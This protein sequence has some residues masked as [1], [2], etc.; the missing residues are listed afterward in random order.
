VPTPPPIVVVPA[1]GTVPVGQTQALQVS[2]VAGT[3]ALTVA[4]PSIVDASVDQ[5]SRIV[6]LTG[7]QPGSTTLTVTDS[8]GLTRVVPIR[9]AYS[10]GTVAPT[11]SIRITGDPASIAFVKARAVA[12]ARSLAQA[13]TGAQIVVSNNDAV[14]DQ[15][16]GQDD[17]ADVDVPILIQGES[18]FSVNAT[19]R[20]H[21][22]NVAA[23][24]IAPDA[25]MVSDFP[26]TLTEDGVL[27]TADLNRNVPSRFLY[28]HANP[29]GQPDRRIVLRAQN[30]SPE[31]AV[32]QFIEGRANA[33][34]NELEVGHDST[35]RFIVHLLQNEGTL[36][37]IPANSTLD[38]E[39]QDLP[40]G[41]VVS[42]TLQLRVLD[43]GAVHLTLFAQ[44]ASA[45]PNEPLTSDVL[46]T[47][48]HPHARGIYGIPEFHYATQW[49]VTDPYLEL[50]VGEI[51]LPNQLK[52]QA[53]A[54][55]YG[56]LQSF[57]VNVENPLPTPQAIAIYENP[58]G[59]RATGTFLID[60]TL[61]QSHQTS[62]Y[63]R[64]KLRQ[65]IVPAKGFVRITIVT[66]PEPGSS[67][68]LNL[69]LAPDDGSVPPGAPGSPIY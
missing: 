30:M 15:P 48:S 43:G 35:K 55:D 69:I 63:S 51:P 24:R 28:F 5:E 39:A 56:V 57:V 61:L 25:L 54:G 14:I 53:L 23:P 59:G 31:P 13:R 11:A 64:F 7:K 50:S 2:S 36:V 32:V 9:V 22:E 42:N 65:Y 49:N 45:D 20:V 17:V 19:T 6:T 66:M 18:Y 3:I 52:G 16:L 41:T 46:L 8:R 47:S 29:A 1:A 26:E 68:P 12:L 38:L 67:Y 33:G 40:A 10:A 60:G 34:P 4:D 44:D 62:A 58:R 37:V 27:F 21:V